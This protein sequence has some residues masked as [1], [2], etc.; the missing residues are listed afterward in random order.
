MENAS[1]P[2]R[3]AHNSKW[4]SGITYRGQVYV[5]P[6]AIHAVADPERR[7]SSQAFSLRL[8]NRSNDLN[9][10]VI[11]ECLY[12]SVPNYKAKYAT[13]VTPTIVD[14]EL[15]SV[16][17]LYVSIPEPAISYPNF[18]QRIKRLENAGR[19]TQ[20]TVRFAASA[21]KEDWMIEHGGGRRIQFTYDGD[22]FTEL[23]G[24]TF[25]SIAAFMKKIGRYDDRFLIRRRLAAQWPID[26]ALTEPPIPQTERT[27]RIY[28]IS[29]I[30]D[31]KAYIGLTILDATSRFAQHLRK[32]SEG[33][34]LPFYQALINHGPDAFTL[35]ILEDSLLPEEVGIREKHWISALGTQHPAG[36]NIAAG[37]QRGGGKSKPVEYQGEKF[38]S[39]E[40]AATVLGKRYDLPRHVVIKRL[41]NGVPLQKT[42]RKQSKHA[43]AGTPH[44]RQWASMINRVDK[45]NG[46]TLDPLWR[47]YDQFLADVGRKPDGM[48]KLVRIDPELAWAP[49]NVKWTSNQDHMDAVNGQTM[50]VAGTTYPSIKALADAYQIGVSTLKNRLSKQGMTPEEAVAAPLGKTSRKASGPISFEGNEYKSIHE[51]SRIISEAA[52]E[53]YEVTRY[54]IR[55]Y[56][57]EQERKTS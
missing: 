22:Q 54:R 41:S 12:M 51:A 15:V 19:L 48:D 10:V 46:G 23:A 3:R 40:E 14:G 17:D 56:L 34:E 25:P 30:A 50:T 53:V 1:S 24:Q 18:R 29:R 33:S 47:D 5:G 35:E 9:D 13:R 2:G 57:K 7:V 36:F 21:S 6:A 44:W 31:G 11:D 37:G 8:S 16:N 32:A 55:K 52:G 43:A 26:V 38:P 45:K 4:K 20:T 49:G 39:I 28:K 42:A 27:Y